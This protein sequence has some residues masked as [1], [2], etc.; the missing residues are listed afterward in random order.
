[1][2]SQEV[3]GR[4]NDFFER[5]NQNKNKLK[6][7]SFWRDGNCIEGSELFLVIT[8]VKDTD[9]LKSQS[10]ENSLEDF[11]LSLGSNGSDLAFMHCN[12]NAPGEY[13]AAELLFKYS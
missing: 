13:G 2:V 10:L 8:C 11:R 6:I 1:M 3:L 5:Y 7:R 9:S 4:I 12:Y